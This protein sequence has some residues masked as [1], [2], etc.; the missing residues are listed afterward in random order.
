MVTEM[1]TYGITHVPVDYYHFRGFRYTSLK[2]AITQAKRMQPH[3]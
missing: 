3:G 1:A 2:E